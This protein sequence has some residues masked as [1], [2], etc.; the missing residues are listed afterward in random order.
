M[1]FD[2]NVFF[3]IHRLDVMFP[4]EGVSQSSKL[5][6]NTIA[7]ALSVNEALINALSQIEHIIIFTPCG[8][9]FPEI[10]HE[11]NLI[12]DCK[13]PRF[14]YIRTTAAVFRREKN[15]QNDLTYIDRSANVAES[16]IVS[17]FCF[18]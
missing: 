3:D 10:C 5:K 13:N 12:I 8:S 11:G 1:R 2:R 9:F 15:I 14:E 4:V 17:P 16:A 7:F 6:S 18:P